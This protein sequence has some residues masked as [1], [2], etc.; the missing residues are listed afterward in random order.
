VTKPSKPGFV[1]FGITY[2]GL[3]G[4]FCAEYF[5]VL[6]GEAAFIKGVFFF[7]QPWLLRWCAKGV[8]CHQLHGPGE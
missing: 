5:S 7:G 8:L 1:G 4:N 3:I 2:L 6:P